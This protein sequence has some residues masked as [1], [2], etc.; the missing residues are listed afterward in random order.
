MAEARRKMMLGQALERGVCRMFTS[1]QDD[2]AGLAFDIICVAASIALLP[3]GLGVIG[4]AGLIGG[5]MVL[6]ADGVAYG[7]EI[8]GNDEGAEAFKKRSEGVRLVGT[9]MT[10]PDFAFGGFR[11]IR[12][13]KEIRGL[14]ALDRTT[15][16]A[17][18]TIGPRTARADRAARYA[19]IAERAHLRTQIRSK[20]IAASLKLEMA[21]RAAAAG[22]TSLLLRE[23][24]TNDKSL[25]HQITR[26]L[27]FHLA[28]GHK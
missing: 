15:A 1:H 14:L 28:S 2:A 7:M 12:E 19:Q 17:A 13:L 6:V 4:F 11:A 3:T 25:M 24:V 20:Q 5:S 27:S 26:Q 8:G 9:I 22:G 16:R 23:E 21:P 10:L 18:E